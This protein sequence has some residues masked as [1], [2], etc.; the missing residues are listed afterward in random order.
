MDY[1]DAN[2]LPDETVVHRATL[3]WLIFGKAMLVVALGVGLL[4]VEPTVGALVSVVG[5]VMSLPAWIAYKTSEFG[6]TTK[7]VI[8]KVGL[9][10]RR[11]LELL[12][13]QVEA[14]AVDQS[15]MGRMFN[16]GSVTL[17][18]T[19]GVREVFH[20]IAAPLEFRRKIQSQTV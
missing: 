11:T 3:H 17:S 9:V 4:A 7:R 16:Y 13:R 14:I 2:L 20:D 12:L 5:L 15:I 19:G 18:G 1:I 8:V 10:Q 6:V